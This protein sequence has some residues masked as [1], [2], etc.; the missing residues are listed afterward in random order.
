MYQVSIGYDCRDWI[1]GSNED[2]TRDKLN[3]REEKG[4]FWNKD[5]NE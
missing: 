1:E 2:G 4:E 3:N 5:G